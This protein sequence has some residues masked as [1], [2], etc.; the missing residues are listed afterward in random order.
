VLMMVSK[1]SHC[2]FAPPAL[3]SS[4]SSSSLP[5]LVL[6]VM[7]SCAVQNLID[8]VTCYLTIHTQVEP[9]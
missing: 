8:M 7:V 9:N 1:P 6:A 4:V 5:P 2:R 3:S